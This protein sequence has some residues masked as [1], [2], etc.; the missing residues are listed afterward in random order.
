MKVFGADKISRLRGKMQTEVDS[1]V[2]W[3]DESL[4]G[5]AKQG[6]IHV[7]TVF[8]PMTMNVISAICAGTNSGP[9]NPKTEGKDFPENQT[10]DTRR[11]YGVSD[12]SV[13]FFFFF[14]FWFQTFESILPTAVKSPALTSSSLLTLSSCSPSPQMAREQFY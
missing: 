8:T 7:T 11:V 10:K 13:L 4:I 9:G 2:Q 14:F 12:I 5:D 3:I 1:W 6:N